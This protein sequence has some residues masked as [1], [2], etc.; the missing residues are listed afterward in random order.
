MASLFV[1]GALILAQQYYSDAETLF[2]FG[3]V[4]WRDTI[5]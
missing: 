2:G 4:I 5:I 1:G 3:V